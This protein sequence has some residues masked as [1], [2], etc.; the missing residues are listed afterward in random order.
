MVYG[1]Q[2]SAPAQ[3]VRD[4]RAGGRPVAG[5]PGSV[6]TSQEELVNDLRAASHRARSR[7]RLPDHQEVSRGP[8]VTPT[9]RSG[10][11]SSPRSTRP[12]RFQPAAQPTSGPLGDT[13]T[14]DLRPLAVRVQVL[15]ALATYGHCPLLGGRLDLVP[16]TDEQAGRLT[17]EIV[18]RV[19]PD[20]TGASPGRAHRCPGLRS[21][22][23][24]EQDV[25]WR[26]PR[27]AI[28]AGRQAH[29]HPVG[30]RQIQTW[31]AS[32]GG[33][34]LASTAVRETGDLG[35]ARQT[36]APWTWAR[37]WSS[38]SRRRAEPGHGGR[39]AQVEGYRRAGGSPCSFS[40][41]SPPWPKPRPTSTR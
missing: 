9:R 30:G 26:V 21:T 7:P 38:R 37:S 24:R 40:T 27:D 18:R 13:E 28:R 8:A 32:P 22:A 6:P 33:W 3:P 25:P 35:R 39:P 15:A 29:H 12:L 34:F 36:S 10:P 1:R 5:S 20:P 23:A 4:P 16:L 19:G 31:C 11:G 14:A 2:T 41:R 17:A